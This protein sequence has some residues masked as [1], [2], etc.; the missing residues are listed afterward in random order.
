M[1]EFSTG[2]H[3]GSSTPRVTVVPNPAI[4]DV[5]VRCNGVDLR[6]VSILAADGRRVH[7]QHVSGKHANIDIAGF[8]AG[9]YML[10]LEGSDGATYR[11]S[12]IKQEP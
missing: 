6:Y 8:A 7:G 3:E 5:E 11:T 9:M 1:A 4:A 12:F 10:L 2:V